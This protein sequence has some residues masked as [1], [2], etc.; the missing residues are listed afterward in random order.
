MLF[1]SY[2][3]TATNTVSPVALSDR[4]Y[5]CFC[6]NKYRVHVP[7]DVSAHASNQGDLWLF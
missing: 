5:L 3:K 7:V 1:K 4:A 2:Y 6:H